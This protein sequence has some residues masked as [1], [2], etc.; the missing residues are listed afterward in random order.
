MWVRAFVLGWNMHTKVE[1]RSYD[2]TAM[3]PLQVYKSEEEFLNK[4]SKILIGGGV[5]D[6]KDLN[7]FNSL[8]AKIYGSYGMT[9][10]IT[11]IAIKE[12]FPLGP[13]YITV[14]QE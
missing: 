3:V 1:A 10:T 12:I 7:R 8:K 4:F 9:E 14:Y 5:Y 11:H 6:K 13:K 2:F